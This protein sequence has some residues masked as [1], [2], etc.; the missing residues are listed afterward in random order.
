MWFR[1]HPSHCLHRCGQCLRTCLVIVQARLFWQRSSVTP[2][3]P[4]LDPFPPFIKPAEPRWFHL[5]TESIFYGEFQQV[6]LPQYKEIP[7]RCAVQQWCNSAA[8]RSCLSDICFNY[9]KGKVLRRVCL[10]YPSAIANVSQSV[11]FCHLRLLRNF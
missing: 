10:N 6:S 5:C 7:L 8:D 9:T 2:V 1:P 11:S 4:A 3:L